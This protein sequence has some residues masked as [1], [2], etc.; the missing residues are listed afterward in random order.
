MQL[1]LSKEHCSNSHEQNLIL[2]TFTEARAYQGRRS[3]KC[4]GNSLD[5]LKVLCNNISF[6]VDIF[7][8]GM[9][10]LRRAGGVGD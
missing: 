10:D 9:V 8:V 3:K 5:F 1:N 6:P 4:T 7:A 2:D